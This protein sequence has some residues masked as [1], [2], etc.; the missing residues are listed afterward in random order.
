MAQNDSTENWAEE[1]GRKVWLS[2]AAGRVFR[3]HTSGTIKRIT[4]TMI[5]VEGANGQT[6]R[7]SRNRVAADPIR[8][9]TGR[10]GYG[11]HYMHKND[12]MGRG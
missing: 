7:F 12:Y 11:K 4:K 8:D 10:G 2:L 6:Y 5:I 9:S 1:L 3:T